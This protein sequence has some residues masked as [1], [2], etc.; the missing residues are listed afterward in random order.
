MI[1]EVLHPIS[2]YPPS[3][4]NADQQ[5]KRNSKQI[6][7]FGFVFWKMNDQA[8]CEWERCLFSKQEQNT[9]AH[10]QKVQISINRSTKEKGGGGTKQKTVSSTGPPQWNFN[11]IYLIIP[12]RW[13][14]VTKS[15]LCSL[16]L[17]PASLSINFSIRIWLIVS[18]Q[19]RCHINNNFS[20]CWTR[21]GRGDTPASLSETWTQ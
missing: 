6:F 20:Q 13:R 21:G 17:S 14:E 7:F 12:V 11:F 4:Q 10:T 1:K 8:V 16:S 15:C 2:V 18:V 5:V 3:H 19:L 9:H